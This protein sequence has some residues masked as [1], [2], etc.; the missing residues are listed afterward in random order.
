[1]TKMLDKVDGEPDSVMSAFAKVQEAVKEL[2]IILETP[3]FF[4]RVDSETRAAE[5]KEAVEHDCGKS[6]HGE[7]GCIC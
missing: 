6:A 5:D 1:M 3:D 4:D 2:Q 7:D